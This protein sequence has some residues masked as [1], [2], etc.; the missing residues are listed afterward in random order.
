M[1][2]A[3]LLRWYVE[4]K[5]VITNLYRT[6]E[7]K[8]GNVFEWFV[9]EVTE[10]RCT[11]DVDKSKALLGDTFKLLGNSAYG[12]LIEAVEC[13]TNMIYTKEEK[14]ID[15]A[16]QSAYFRDLDEIGKACELRVPQFYYDFLDKYIEGCDFKLIQMDTDSLYMG[17]SAERLE[18]LV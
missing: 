9:K 17:I 4:H 15:R 13:Q 5:A 18:D 10:A 16:L 1:L 12:K 8:V 3:S 2:Y 7:Y 11:R 14:V 6:I